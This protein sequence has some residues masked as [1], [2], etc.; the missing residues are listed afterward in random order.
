MPNV[1]V[2][3][4]VTTDHNVLKAPPA[5]K[6]SSVAVPARVTVVTGSRI[7]WLGPAFT[8]GPLL[9]GRTV[10]RTSALEVICES[11]TLRRRM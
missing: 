10:I 9:C 6:P 3:G 11:L 5:G 4:P 7:V 8:V 1:A 2:P